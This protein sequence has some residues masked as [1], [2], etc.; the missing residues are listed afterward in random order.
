MNINFEKIIQKNISKNIA[1]PRRAMVYVGFQCHQK[2]GFCY[3]KHKCTE[4]MFDFEIIKQQIDF[5]YQYG[6][7]DFE[8]TG[9]E[10]SEYIELRKVCDYIKQKDSNSKIAIITNGGLW[11]SNVWDL[12]DEVLV[13]Y[14]ACKDNSLLDKN[15]FP[16]GST[17]EKV[18]KTIDLAHKLNKIVR[19]NTVC[20]TFNLNYLD[21]IVDDLVEFKPRIIN[22]L[23]VNLFD[24][25]INMDKYIDY[26]LLRTKLK[27]LID[28]INICL[29]DVAIYVRYMPFCD[30]EGYEKYILGQVQHIYDWFD[31]NRE[32]DG[33][34]LL[35]ICQDSNFLKKLGKYGS[36]SIAHALKTRSDLYYKNNKCLTCKYCIV[37]DGVENTKTEMLNKFIQPKH[38]KIIYD[39]LF[40]FKGNDYLYNKL[41]SSKQT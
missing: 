24:Q 3:Y 14:H 35:D 21:R 7:R 2:C 38:G 1:Q 31:W 20:A 16:L 25:A 23:P 13:S 9:G 37:C 27:E 30:M 8:I 28:K 39:P 29:K 10:P 34:Q 32:L 36:T 17:Y 19:T 22:F 11:K 18:K 12:I 26:S 6:I 41:Y 40:Y 5:E 33:I 15:I 4:K